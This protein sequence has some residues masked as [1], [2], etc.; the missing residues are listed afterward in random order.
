MGEEL[1]LAPGEPTKKTMAAN[2]DWEAREL[3]NILEPRVGT[4]FIARKNGDEH[5][6]FLSLPGSYNVENALPAVAAARHM[7]ISWENIM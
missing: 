3:K 7:D 1:P 5:K 4:Q 6:L 2:L